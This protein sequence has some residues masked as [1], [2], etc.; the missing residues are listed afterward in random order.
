[1]MQ[2][3]GHSQDTLTEARFGL[4][5]SRIAYDFDSVDEL[6]QSYTTGMLSARKL[7][8]VCTEKFVSAVVKR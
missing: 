6:T 1:M 4:F 7:F 3:L 5:S 8:E 2:T